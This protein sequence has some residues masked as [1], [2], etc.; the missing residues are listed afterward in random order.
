MEV[1]NFNYVEEARIAMLYRSK[2]WKSLNEW[3]D[4]IERWKNA[5]FDEIDVN[6][7]S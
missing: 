4:L 2:L 5:M 6:S 7:I 1:T 3:I